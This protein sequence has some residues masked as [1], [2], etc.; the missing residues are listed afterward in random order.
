MPGGGYDHNLF[1]Y[2]AAGLNE[3]DYVFVDAH[4]LSSPVLVDVNRDGHLD[5][6]IAISYYFDKAEYAGKQLDF[7][8]SKYIAGG[9]VCWDLENQEW[10]WTVHLDLT[11]DATQYEFCVS[12]VV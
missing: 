2:S 10:I 8:P 9:L 4:S 1:Y 12:D 7:D 5:V 6:V 11:T 3:S